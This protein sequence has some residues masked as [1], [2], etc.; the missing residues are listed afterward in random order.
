MSMAQ[1]RKLL[2]GAGGFCPQQFKW[3]IAVWPAPLQVSTTRREHR[4]P[5]IHRSVRKRRQNIDRFAEY[6]EFVAAFHM[7][8]GQRR[9][10]YSPARSEH[11]ASRVRVVSVSL[12]HEEADEADRSPPFSNVRTGTRPT[13]PVIREAVA[14][15]G[16]E[17]TGKSPEDVFRYL[18][19]DTRGVPRHRGSR[20]P[21]SIS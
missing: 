1:K 10:S 5:P 20:R 13:A 12:Y 2:R 4:S 9:R 7:H 18:S 8:H 16:E 17:L 15:L 19:T 6:L 3:P 14:R 21:T 11:E